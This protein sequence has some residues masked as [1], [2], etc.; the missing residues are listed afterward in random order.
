MKQLE[1]PDTLQSSLDYLSGLRTV[2][3]TLP[4]DDVLALI[5][6]LHDAYT[7]GKRIFIVGNGGSAATASHMAC[8]LS[9]TVL[10][11]GPLLPDKRFR[12]IA[13]TDNVPLITAWG[14]DTHYDKIFAEQLRNLAEEGDLLV[15]ITASGN[16]Q[17]IVEVVKVAQELGVR[18]VGLLGFDGGSVK[19]LLQESVVIKSTD[20]GHIEDAHMIL[21]H[22]V[23]SYFK[24]L[25]A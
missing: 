25:C 15:V 7:S 5:A 12:A 2:L 20:Y 4:L 16:S 10:G 22:L 8:D 3:D 6:A 9:K 23:T 13:L 18:P 14:N 17:N 1:R 19:E 21:T 11:R 24:Q